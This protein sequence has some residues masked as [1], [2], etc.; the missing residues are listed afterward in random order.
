MCMAPAPPF[1]TVLPPA[2]ARCTV[3]AAPPI[4]AGALRAQT[5]QRPRRCRRFPGRVVFLLPASRLSG[6]G[7]QPCPERIPSALDCLPR[8]A[9]AFVLQREVPPIAELGEPAQDLWELEL[10]LTQHRPTIKA[11]IQTD[12]SPLRTLG[13][14]RQ[15]GPVLDMDVD[16][17][18]RHALQRSKRVL[19][20][21]QEV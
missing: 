8:V 1:W 17:P 4:R 14:R 3:T 9:R 5:H 13:A 15:D 19:T 16:N 10:A 21:Q 12:E 7:C 18:R 20:G 11:A 2:P 6:H